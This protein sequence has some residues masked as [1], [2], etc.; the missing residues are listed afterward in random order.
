MYMESM[1]GIHWDIV[2]VQDQYL[3]E[4]LLMAINM[5]RIIE[6]FMYILLLVS[7]MGSFLVILGKVH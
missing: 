4:A 5:V 1:R 2:L 3:R 6:G 7:Q